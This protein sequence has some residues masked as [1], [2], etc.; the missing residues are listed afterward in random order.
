MALNSFKHLKPQFSPLCGACKA[1]NYDTE[2]KATKLPLENDKGSPSPS[3]S[4]QWVE[5]GK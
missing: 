4:K 5:E 3:V 1:G 2:S